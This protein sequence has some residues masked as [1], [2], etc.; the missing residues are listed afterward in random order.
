MENELVFLGED[1]RP[2]TNSLKVA[3]L[4][5]KEHKNVIR[6]IENICCSDTFRM[7]NFEHTPYTHQ[8]NGQTYHY[9]LMTKD[10]F[11]FLVMGYTGA[12]AAQFKEAYINA[13]NEMERRLKNAQPDLSQITKKDLVRML[14]ESETECERLSKESAEK[15]MVIAQMKTSIPSSSVEKRMD[16]VEHLLMLA[17]EPLYQAKNTIEKPKPRKPAVVSARTLVQRK[18]PGSMLLRDMCQK[19]ADE[20]NISIRTKE[21][22]NLFRKNGWLLTDDKQFNCPSEECVKNQWMIPS[23]SGLMGNGIQYYTPYVTPKGYEYFAS[24]IIKQEN[25]LWTKK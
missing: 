24:V 12:K 4:F 8:Q 11:T 13:F 22:F 9:Y 20:R 16:R 6:D 19:L 2:V 17:L 5:G 14:L 21:L 23:P 10:G 7:L 18:A 1:G 3:E 25:N 15:D